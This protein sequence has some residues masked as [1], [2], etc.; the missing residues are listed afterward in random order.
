M[1]EAADA[2][3][4]VVSALAR[5][6]EGVARDVRR[7]RAELRPG[8]EPQERVLTVFSFLPEHGPDLLREI[9]ARMVVPL[10]SG[11]RVGAP[12]PVAE[13]V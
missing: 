3:K 4:K 1:L 11:D 9:A 6:G 5:T 13:P 8:G 7:A 10:G 12:A 2:E